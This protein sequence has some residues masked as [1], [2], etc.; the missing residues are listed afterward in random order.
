MSLF[1]KDATSNLT[2]AIY[3]NGMGLREI[4]R[5]KG[6]ASHDG[7]YLGKTSKYKLPRHPSQRPFP[8]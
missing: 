1:L 4:E 3:V 2:A 6:Y 7:D 8:M 5:V